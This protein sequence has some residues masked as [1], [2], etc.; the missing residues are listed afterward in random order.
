M[1]LIVD[2]GTGE[3]PYNV[4]HTQTKAVFTIEPDE[5]ELLDEIVPRFVGFQIYQAILSAQA[6][7]HAARMMAMRNASDN[8]RE[9]LA[10][11]EMDYNKLRQQMI[12]NEILDIVGGSGLLEDKDFV[13]TQS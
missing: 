2:Y 1:P 3:E 9:L 5:K 10:Y 4:T 8:A 7:E 6:S 13:T 12:T 11:L